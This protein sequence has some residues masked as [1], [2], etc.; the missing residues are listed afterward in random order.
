MLAINFQYGY[1]VLIT[2]AKLEEPCLK[3]ESEWKDEVSRHVVC[4]V[5]P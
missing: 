4:P 5:T 1:T 2:G 3:Q